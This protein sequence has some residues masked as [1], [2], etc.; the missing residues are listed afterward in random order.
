MNGNSRVPKTLYTH[1][2]QYPAV[3]ELASH[4][5]Y[6]GRESFLL[7]NQLKFSIGEIRLQD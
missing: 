7:K 4:D 3:A 5:L 6:S 2:S 1:L